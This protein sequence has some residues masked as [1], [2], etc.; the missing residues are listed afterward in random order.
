M[1]VPHSSS[2][3]GPLGTPAQSAQVAP[4][5]DDDD[6]DGNGAAAAPLPEHP[7][8]AAHDDAYD[9]AEGDRVV[10]AATGRVAT[11]LD[12]DREADAERDSYTLGFEDGRG[13]TAVA[14]ED[15]IMPAAAAAQLGE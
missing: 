1:Q 2:L 12:V 11:I 3:E 5:A 6:D 14:N 15:E 13:E 7:D 9:Y 10:H 8:Q 4:D